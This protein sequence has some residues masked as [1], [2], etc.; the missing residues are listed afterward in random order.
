MVTSRTTSS[1]VFGF[2]PG[3][4]ATYTASCN[5][6]ESVAGG[7]FSLQAQP[8]IKVIDSFVANGAFQVTVFNFGG[9][10]EQGVVTV[11]ANCMK[12]ASATT[13]R[14]TTSPVFTL[15]A[16]NTASFTGTCNTGE[17]LTGG[18]FSLQAQASVKV[19]D[20]FASNG[21]FKVTL[22]NTGGG[23]VQGVV[24]VSAQCLG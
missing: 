7:G 19:I 12:G 13:T 6:G 3:I 17:A 2:N 22:F 5:Q 1:P 15:P 4:G 18:G 9:G 24:T 11:S 16:G 14:N 10:F 8:D 20:S 21:V 23:S